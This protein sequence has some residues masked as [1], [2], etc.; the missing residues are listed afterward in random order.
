MI[1]LFNGF[2]TVKLS[3]GEFICKQNENCEYIDIIN[4]GT[5]EI[6]SMISFIWVLDFYTYIINA[7]DNII[8]NLI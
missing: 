4:S 5:Y 6:Y 1:K 2:S 7:K 8:N 3:R